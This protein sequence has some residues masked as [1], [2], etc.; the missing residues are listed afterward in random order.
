MTSL[1]QYPAAACSFIKASL[2]QSID[3]QSVEYFAS[4]F[5]RLRP[6]FPTKA[7]YSLQVCPRKAPLSKLSTSQVYFRV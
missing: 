7:L 5:I 1:E 4:T 3:P 2:C 6:S